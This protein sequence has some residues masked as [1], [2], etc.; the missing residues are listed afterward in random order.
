MDKNYVIDVGPDF[1]Q[2]MLASGNEDLHA[3]LLTHEHNDHVIGLDDLRPFIFKS[4]KEMTIYGLPRVLDE[5]KERFNY[6][7]KPQAYPGAPSFELKP[8]DESAEVIIDDLTI[9]PVRIEHGKLPILGFRIK[10]F[11]YLTDMKSIMQA[12]KNK[13]KNLDVLVID[14]LRKETHHSHLSL[15]ESLNFIKEFRP[16]QAYLIHLSHRMGKHE[17]I[18]KDLPSGVSIA[19]DG[20]VLDI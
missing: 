14:S 20:L 16:K 9:I 3:V 7:F 10:D 11:A 19:Y 17:D 2:Q 1:R 18:E 4:K 6:A 13:L 8:I 12:E 5:I 15:Q